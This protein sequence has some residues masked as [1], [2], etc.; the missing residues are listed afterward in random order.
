M[1]HVANWLEP[2]NHG[3]SVELVKA[4]LETCRNKEGPLQSMFRVIKV[5]DSEEKVVGCLSPKCFQSHTVKRLE[6]S[7][8]M[9]GT[10]KIIDSG[11]YNFCY[12]LFQ[13]ENGCL[14]VCKPFN[15]FCHLN[16]R[17]FDHENSKV[18]RD[19]LNKWYELT[20]RLHIHQTVGK[21]IQDIMDKE[22]KKWRAISRITIDVI[23]FL[24]KQNL[25]FGGHRED[26]RLQVAIVKTLIHKTRYLSWNCEANCRI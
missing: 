24:S 26:L 13:S 12:K 4:G 25:S 16:P 23:F 22:R 9:V 11:L 6:G 8:I 5:G 20:L 19:C 17:L 3:I 18:H 21:G 2:I 15:T 10:L 1:C 7:E 14:F